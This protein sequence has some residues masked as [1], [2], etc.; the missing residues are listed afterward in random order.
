MTCSFTLRAMCLLLIA[1]NPLLLG[2]QNVVLNFTGMTPHLG[3]KLEARLIDKRDL[4][5]VDRAA[6][7]S[8]VSANFDLT[9][10]GETGG[11]YFIDFYADLSGN[12]VYDAPPVDHAWREEADNL[13]SGDNTVDFAHNTSFTDV[14]WRH[15]L[16]FSLL[17]M[18]PH[19]GQLLG[20]RLIDRTRT[21]KEAGRLVIAGVPSADFSIDLPFLELGHSYYL[22]FFADLSG[23]GLYDAPPVDH[24]W[25]LEIDAVDGDETASFSHGTNF[26][27]IGWTDQVTVA[28]TDMNPH[29]GQLLE[30]RVIDKD[31]GKEIGRTRRTVDVA[32]I[33]VSVP[34]LQAGGNYQ[35]DFYA[36]LNGN[37]TYNA[38]GAD[39]AWRLDWEGHPGGD[40]LLPFAHNT[41]FVDVDWEYLFTLHFTDMN[42]HLGQL[43]ALRLVNSGTGQEVG[44]F[45]MPAIMFPEFYVEVPGIRLDENYDADFYADLNGNGA[46]DAPPADHAWRLNFDDETGDVEL[47]FAHNTN[48]T[49]I[50][51]PASVHLPSAV[52]S[53]SAFPNPFD[54]R[55]GLQFGLTQAQEVRLQ[56]FDQYGRTVMPIRELHALSGQN[57]VELDGLGQLP[58]GIYWLRVELAPAGLFVYPLV[59]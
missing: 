7:P 12:G 9:L 43:L 22:D 46:Y 13:A 41:S 35:V 56:L 53:F 17:D 21:G 31:S 55:V 29:V 11:S 59:K 44:S 51:F 49:D 37:G 18:T 50:E 39:H 5:E 57:T 3:Q 47:E 23:N 4:Q 48:F 40:A 10:V 27:D 52:E 28:M 45:S 32:A 6:I 15:T 16:T 24:A 36:D 20:V 30:L 25:R 8:I 38:P 14:R 42:P 54:D 58:P 2:G 34:G 1:M 19:L 33:D 26:T